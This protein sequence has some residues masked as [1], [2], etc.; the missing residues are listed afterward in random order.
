MSPVSSMDREPSDKRMTSESS[1][2]AVWPSVTSSG[3]RMFPETLPRTKVSPC[4]KCTTRTPRS[5]ASARIRSIRGDLDVTA[6]PEFLH[7]E[8][9][10]NRREPSEMVLVR[11]G[12]RDHFDLLQPSR[13]QIRRDH[14]FADIDSGVHP[15]RGKASER[16]ARVD[17]H[18]AP[19][20]KCDEQAVTLADV[21]D[22][23][24]EILA[25]E[26]RRKRIRRD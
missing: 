21:Q 17:Q 19:A 12:E 4:F 16:A 2:F 10:K 5:R 8:I 6:D 23:H 1:F 22:R 20:G 15:A 11:M 25:V 7:S 26:M 24:L 3:H 13:P 18:R 9:R 14:V